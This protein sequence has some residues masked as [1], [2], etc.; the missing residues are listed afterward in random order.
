MTEQANS[1]T[2][3]QRVTRLEERM[4]HQRESLMGYRADIKEIKTT[5]AELVAN[6]NRNKWLL[7]G[8]VG[9]FVAQQMG[10]VEFIKKFVL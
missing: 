1:L 6:E 9:T 3:E 7:I 10:M 5:L 4:D 8:I 2:L